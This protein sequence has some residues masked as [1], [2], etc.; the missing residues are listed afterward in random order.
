ME[1]AAGAGFLAKFGELVF[2][3][4]F[5]GYGYRVGRA[6]VI[7]LALGIGFGWL[8]GL[9]FQQGAIVPADKDIRNDPRAASCVNWSPSACPAMADKAIPLFNPWIYSADVMIPVIGFGQK[10]AWTPTHDRNIEL[11]ILGR[12]ERPT[13]FVYG[14]QLAETVLGW[15]GSVLL[16]SFVSGLIA[17]E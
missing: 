17:K 13:S 7:L 12:K 4:W 6:L 9:A 11:P 5:L 10:S 16:L 1:P 2:V 8:Y 14:M 3:A 15:V